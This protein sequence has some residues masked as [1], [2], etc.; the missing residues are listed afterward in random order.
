MS[1][2]FE[3]QRVWGTFLSTNC[4]LSSITRLALGPAW[5]RS[6]PVLSCCATYLSLCVV[7]GK[8]LAVRNLEVGLPEV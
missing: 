6:L 2:I 1:D 4:G 7:K 3:C 8:V 5:C